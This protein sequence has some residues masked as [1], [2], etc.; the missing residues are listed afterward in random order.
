M[1]D[2]FENDELLE[3]LRTEDPAS[4]ERQPERPGER[5]A[6]RAHARALFDSPARPA[7]PPASPWRRRLPIAGA[8]AGLVLAAVVTLVLGGS[9]SR[10]AL[11]LAINK[12]ERYVTLTL[13]DP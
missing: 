5:D 6:V 10:P 8:V 2:G 1:S 3:R 12:G 11:A 13:N 7:R 4:G 9:S